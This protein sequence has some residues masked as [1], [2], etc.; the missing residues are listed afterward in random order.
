ML[1]TYWA[2]PRPAW[3]CPEGGKEFCLHEIWMS[4]QEKQYVAELG[5]KI[6]TLC[7]LRVNWVCRFCMER[8]RLAV[9]DWSSRIIKGSNIGTI[10]SYYC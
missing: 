9:K 1:H 7:L 6:G 2:A 3:A 4:F 10:G 8:L 5:M